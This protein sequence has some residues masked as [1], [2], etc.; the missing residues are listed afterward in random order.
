MLY[1]I[2]VEI[3]H[4][5]LGVIFNTHF[6][7]SYYIDSINIRA[8]S[9]IIIIKAIAGN[10]WGY[11]KETIPIYLSLFNN[12][13]LSLPLPSGSP[14]LHHQWSRNFEYSKILESAYPPAALWWLLSIIYSR[15]PKWF[16]SMIS[17]LYY[18]HNI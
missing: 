11:Q 2:H 5:I 17:F 7:F 3:R 16:L 8:S 12:P 15:K 13:F 1:L 14:T 18:I 4:R 9:R 6:I 10:N